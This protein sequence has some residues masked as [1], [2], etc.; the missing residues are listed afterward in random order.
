MTAEFLLQATN[1]SM[2]A[3]NSFDSKTI[4]DGIR[5][6][7]E[8]DSAFGPG[9]HD[10]KGGAYLAYLAYHA[11]RQLCAATERPLLGVTQLYVSDEEIGS[12]TSRALI[13]AEGRRAKYVLVTEPARD[14]GSSD[15]NFTAAYTATLDGLGVD[16]KGAHTHYEQIYISSIEPRA[17]LLH[18]LYQTL[19]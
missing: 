3:S 16:G 14:G 15:G 4:L 17:R 7:V 5:R 13:E 6:W 8:I 12:P 2:T 19:R 9:I 11:F 1:T 18:R 10:M